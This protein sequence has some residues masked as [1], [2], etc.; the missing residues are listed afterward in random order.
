[1]AKRY[2]PCHHKAVPSLF[3]SRS[4][5]QFP[6]VLGAEDNKPIAIRSD[7]IGFLYLLVIFFPVGVSWPVLPFLSSNFQSTK[8]LGKRNK[9]GSQQ[10][11]F[12]QRRMEKKNKQKRSSFKFLTGFNALVPLSYI[13]IH[14]LVHL[15]HGLWQSGWESLSRQTTAHTASY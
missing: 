2:P 1:M 4:V 11:M 14:H 5:W 9:P 8:W 15:S 10:K 6:P 3:P 12:R 13:L 7:S